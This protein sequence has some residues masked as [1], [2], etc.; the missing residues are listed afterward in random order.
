MRTITKRPLRA[1]NTETAALQSQF[2]QRLLAAVKSGGLVVDYAHQLAGLSDDEISAAAEAAQEKGLGGRWLLPLLNTTQQPA[3][4]SLKDRQTRENLFAAGWT[5]NQKGDANDTRELVLRLAALRAR[6]AQLLGADD[7]A[8]WSMAD[9]MA[10]DPAE[11]FAFMRR[12]A[13]QRRRGQSRNWRIF[14]KL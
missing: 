5:R 12:I 9:Q 4:L 2:Q 3:L 1:L 6:K 7:F 8:S 10:G 14:S 11:A 13:P